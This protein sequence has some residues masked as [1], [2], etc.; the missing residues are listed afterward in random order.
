M[1]Y[2]ELTCKIFIKNNIHY[3]ESFHA[4]SKYL[5]YSLGQDEHYGKMI[6][7]STFRPYCFGGFYPIQKDKIYKKGD[8][9]QFTIR[10]IDEA[11]VDILIENM[12]ANIN[13]KDFQVVDVKKLVKTQFQINE[14]YSATPVIVSSEKNEKGHPVYWTMQRCGDIE[15][16]QT[17]LH[18]DLISKY[19]S[20]YEDDID[21][22]HNFIQDLELKNRVPQ[23]IHIKRNNRGHTFFGNKF[24]IIPNE[25]ETS[26]KL[27]FL[28]L[29]VGLGE[30]ANFG[31]GFCLWK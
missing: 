17:K 10:S 11:L 4:I 26:Q 8:T 1:K 22:D 30:K 23:N 7:N 25:D 21:E 15:K 31:G 19:N 9:H 18:S 28:A 2:F 29:C 14:I 27:A 24:K 13:N 6:R 5:N 16:L 20:F 12:R 3:K